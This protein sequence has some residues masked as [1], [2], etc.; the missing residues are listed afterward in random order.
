ML[1]HPMCS[2]VRSQSA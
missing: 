2:C 1:P